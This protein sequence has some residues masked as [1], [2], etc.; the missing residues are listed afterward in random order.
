MGIYLFWLV[1]NEQTDIFL[2]VS[3]NTSSSRNTYGKMKVSFQ[4]ICLK[5]KIDLNEFIPGGKFQE[6]F[7]RQL[8]YTHLGRKFQFSYNSTLLTKP[9]HLQ[10][11]K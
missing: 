8:R 11:I 6:T 5:V 10:M 1:D 9:I 2:F 4:W 3:Q 7:S